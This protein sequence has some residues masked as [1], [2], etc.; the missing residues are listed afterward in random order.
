M[1]QRLSKYARSSLRLPILLLGA[2]LLTMLSIS[3]LTLYALKGQRAQLSKTLRESQEQALAFLANRLEQSLLNA[4]QAPFLVLKNIPQQGVTEER[5][6]FLRLTFPAVEQVLFL[7]RQMELTQSFP[8]PLSEH[9]HR[10]NQWIVQ[11]V[12]EEDVDR[13]DH[14]F[15]LHTFVETLS[16]RPTLFAFQPITDIPSQGKNAQAS[17]ILPEGW[18]LMHFNLDIVRVSR[19]VPLLAEFNEAQGGSARLQD[20][21]LAIEKDGLSVPLTRVL[22][23][24]MLVFEPP[25]VPQEQQLYHQSWAIIGVAGGALLATAII[26]FAVWWE[27]RREYALV[28]LRNRFVANVSH[29]LKTPLSLI[30]MYAETLYLRRLS[31]TQKQH[32]YHRVILREA[33]RLSQM[34]NN[35]LDFARLRA[36]AAIYHLT[37]TDL[38]ATVS[39]ILEHYQPQLEERGVKLEVSL[40]EHLPPVAHDPNGVTQILLNLLDNAVKYATSGG[41]AQVRLVDDLDWVE[42]QVTDF[43]PG[44]PAEEHA[45]LHQAFERGRMA[46]T[47]QGSGLGLALVEQIAAAHRAHFILDTPENHSGIKAVV[48]FPSYKGKS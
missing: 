8:M 20:P 33:E 6:H 40:P 37:E 44:I 29:E 9:Q 4:I 34:I 43:G 2:L 19:V 28:E 45:R 21:E 39:S 38:R 5:L 16:G 46:E 30:R 10:F 17:E 1:A 41:V 13:E 3:G 35:V 7:D 14:P 27:I 47:A 42:L 22:P 18:V 11:R 32:E 31:D 15:S 36:G 25:R 48:S 26:G 24:W 12:Q 23:G